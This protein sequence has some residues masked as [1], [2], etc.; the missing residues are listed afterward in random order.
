MY[1]YDE[2]IYF[3][4]NPRDTTNFLVYVPLRR[5]LGLLP[6]G[7]RSEMTNSDSVIFRKMIREIKK[8]PLIGCKQYEAN[9]DET[10]T[11]HIN[12]TDNCQLRCTYCYNRSCESVSDRTFTKDE[13]T[14]IIDSYAQYVESNNISTLKFALFGGAEPT[15]N[16]ELFYHTVEYIKDISRRHNK[17]Y[18]LTMTTNGFYD[19]SVM[20]YIIDNFTGVTL[21]LDGPKNI[22]D[23]QRITWGNKGSYGYVFPNAKLLHNSSIMHNYRVTVTKKTL[24]KH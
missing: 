10:N 24:G 4:D 14:S 9:F 12:L 5:F 19:D 20:K 6:V 23:A 15:W 3:I 11:L 1:I 2:E 8:H 21:S 17:K 13:I 7:I 16:K 22:H 18:V